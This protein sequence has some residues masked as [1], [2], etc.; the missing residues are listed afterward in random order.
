MEKERAVELMRVTASGV[1]QFWEKCIQGAYCAQSAGRIQT[2]R[3]VSGLTHNAFLHKGFVAFDTNLKIWPLF[4][5]S[6][7]PMPPF[8]A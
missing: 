6:I 3:G 1:K 5:K 7:D 2:L 8:Y 4:Y